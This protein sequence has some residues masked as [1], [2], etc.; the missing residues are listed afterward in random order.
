M[1][2]A[3]AHGREEVI[4][5]AQ[6][7]GIETVLIK[8]LSASILVDAIQQLLGG[9]AALP[10]QRANAGQ[11]LLTTLASIRGARILLAEDNA[12]NQQVASEILLDAGLQVDVAENGQLALAMVEA[13]DYDLVLMDMQMPVLDGLE[14]SRLIRS[15][16]R[17]AKLPIVAMTANVM[18]A[19][20]ERCSAAGMNAFLAKPIEPEELFRTLL[21]WIAPRQP[22]HASRAETHALTGQSSQD[23]SEPFPERIKGLDLSAGLRRLLGKKQRYVSL[24]RNFCETKATTDLDI[25]RALQAGRFEEAERLANTINGLSGQIGAEGLQQAAQAL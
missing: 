13:Q 10:K 24:L 6:G 12:I 23:V 16:P 1:A 19:D 7:A 22:A 9:S 11:Q 3:T 14:A 20:R 8:P 21:Q 18:Q 5:Q 15:L 2:I 4:H 25:E 17:Y